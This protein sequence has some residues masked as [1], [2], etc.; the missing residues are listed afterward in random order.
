MKDQIDLSEMESVPVQSARGFGRL[1]RYWR[2][3][4]E[5]MWDA[6]W[7]KTPSRSYWNAALRGELAH[8]YAVL[9]LRHLQPGVRI[10]EAG[11]GVGQ[12]VLAL[13]QRGYDCWGLDFAAKTIG[14]LRSVFPEVPFHQG[15][16]RAL[17]FANESFDAYVSL[18]V[19]EH[20]TEGQ[21]LMLAEAARVL[22]PGGKMFVSVPAFNGYRRLRARLGTYDQ[23]AAAPFFE[24]CYSREE[25]ELLLREAGFEPLEHQYQNTVMTF[26]Q[27]TPLR[28]FYRPIED[29]RYVRGAVDRALRLVLPRPWFGHMLMIVAAKRHTC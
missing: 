8:D 4:N 17:P 24:A 27:E 20:F 7:Q 26:A 28:P 11:C 10:L 23:S 5:D 29:V 25:L 1:H 9:F 22:R 21:E 3:A 12:V 16:I 14:M 15:D 2:T 18:G 6:L 13:R 19:I